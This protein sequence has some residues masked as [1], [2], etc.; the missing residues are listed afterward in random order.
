MVPEADRELGR[1]EA[2]YDRVPRATARTESIGPF[3]LFVSTGGF[4]FYARPTLGAPGPFTAEDVARVRHR[5]RQ[6]GLAEAFEWVDEMAPD[7]AGAAADAGLEVERH[8][9][10][11]QRGAV[12][13]S[14]PAGYRV[15][16]LAT[17]DPSLAVA[18]AAV[19]TGFNSPGTEVG[20]AGV[21]E[22]DAG[23]VDPDDA[24]LASVRRMM[25]KGLFVMAVAEDDSGPVAGGSHSPRGDVSEITGVATLPSARRRGLAAAVTSALVADARRLGVEVCFLSADSEAVA[26]VY[27]RVGFQR[28]GTACVAEPQRS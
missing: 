20:T 14:P 27:G 3:T 1:I 10:L 13:S 5:Q 26:R 2:Y 8:P 4:S 19:G 17:D 18:R 9:L 22:R 16:L 25:G 28:V 11:V 7:L 15:R 12:A 23:A 6:L 21:A 24:H